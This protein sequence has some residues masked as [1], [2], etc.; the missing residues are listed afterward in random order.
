MESLKTL[1]NQI[2]E[3]HLDFIRKSG[4]MFPGECVWS[5]HLLGSFLAARGYK[6]E[7]VYGSYGMHNLFHVWIKVNEEILDFTLF[8]FLNN[9]QKSRFYVE[10]SIDELLEYIL[11]AQK[12]FWIESNSQYFDSYNELVAIEPLY[13]DVIKDDGITYGEFLNNISQN[14]NQYQSQLNFEVKLK[15]TKKSFNDFLNES[16]LRIGK[17]FFTKYCIAKAC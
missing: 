9:K 16:G 6:T 13:V 8:Q 2:E 5:S 3:K 14:I 10:T 17:K 1:I 7:I 12:S 11:E 4:S 15:E